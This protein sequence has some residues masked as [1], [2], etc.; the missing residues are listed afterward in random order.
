MTE[1]T[2]LKRETAKE[3]SEPDAKVYIDISGEVKK[4]GVYTFDEVPRIVEVVERAG[5]FT[6]KAD[7]TSVNQAQTIEDGTKLV[8]QSKEERKQKKADK[9]KSGADTSD[10]DEEGKINLNTATKEQLMTLSGIGE[11][12]A[13]EILSYREK[14]GNFSKPEELMNISGIKEG[15]YNKLKDF[16]SV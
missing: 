9:K 15:I 1:Q 6:K 4:P 2:E 12:R 5:G 16:I 13:L 11:A 10:S 7:V 14:N 8:I 3:D